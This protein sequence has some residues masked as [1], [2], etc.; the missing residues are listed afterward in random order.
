MLRLVDRASANQDRPAGIVHLANFR[1]D[2]FN[3]EDPVVGRVQS[4]LGPNVT[5]G[6]ARGQVF[7]SAYGPVVVTR[8]PRG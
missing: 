1:D 2:R 3:A 5:I 7:E 8:H 6:A 4:L